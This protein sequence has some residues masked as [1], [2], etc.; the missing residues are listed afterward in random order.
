MPLPEDFRE[1][2]IEGIALKG[3]K[4]APMLLVDQATAVVGGGLEGSRGSST[5]RG[6]TLLSLE[7]WQTVVE[8]LRTPLPWH[9][10]RA[11]V[12]VS[13][14]SLAALVGRRIG[15]GEAVL[16]I[17]GVTDPCELMNELHPGLMVALAGDSAGGVYG[18]VVAGGKIRTGDAVA[19]FNL[20]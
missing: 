15:L 13:G 7:Q 5:R 9:T 20:I 1:G 6:V 18:Q 2:R 17:L 3:L 4:F 16:E 11:N 8:K 14:G 12:L 10:R 19:I